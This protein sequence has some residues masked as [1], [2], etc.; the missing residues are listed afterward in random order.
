VVRKEKISVTLDPTVV[1]ELSDRVGEEYE[2]RSEAVEDLLTTAFSVDEREHEYE[3][4][5][6]ELERE[7]ERLNR[8]RRQLLEQREENQELVRF[9]ESQ[10]ELAEY[11]RERQKRGVFTRFVWWL[12]G[13]PD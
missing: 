8:E 11:E 4:R 13:Q 1:G 2:S 12:R 5:I 3:E 9:A 6:A 7:V 10:R